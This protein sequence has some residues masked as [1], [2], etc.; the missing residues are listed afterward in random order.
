MASTAPN[1]QF[2]SC[3]RCKEFITTGHAYELGCDRWHTHCFACYKCEKP[4]SCESDFLVLGTGA[5]ICFDCSDSCKNCGKKIDDLAIILSSSNEAYCSDCFKC[6]KCGEN[7][8]DLRY[9]KTKRGLFCLSCHEKLLAKR[10]YYEEK[11][12]R[13]KKNLPSLPTPVID[14]GHTDEV[15]ASAVLPEKTFSRPASLVNEI[16]SGSEPSK[17]IETNSSDIVPHFITGYNDSDDNS[18]SSK[19]GSNVSIDVIGPEENSTEHVNDD[20]KEEAEAPSAN[21]SLNVATDPTLSCKEPPSHSRNLLNKTPLRNSSGQYLAKSPSS[22][23]Q[24]IIV[25]DSLEESDQIDPPNNSSRNASELLTSVLHSPVSVNMKNP[26]GSNT[27]IFNTGEISQMDPSLSRKVLNNIVE[28]TNALQRPVVEVVKEDRSVPDLAGVQQEQA[29][30]YSYSNNSGKG[31]KI[32][33]SLSRRSKDLMINLKSRA[34]GKQD[35]NVKLSPASKVTSRRSQDLMRDNDS[36]TGLDTPN[37]N[38]TS[39]DILVNNQKSLNYKRFTD[40]GTL[41]VTSGKEPALEEQKN[42]SFKSP[43]PIDHLLQS[44]ATPSNVSM[45]RTPPL[46]SSLTFDRRNGSSYSNQNYS[47]PSWQKTPK[48]QLENS[49]NFEEQKETLYENSESRNDPSLDKEIVTAEHYLK[50]L[51]INLKEL[52]SQREELMK[53]ITEMKSMKEAL[54]RHFESYNSE[55]N[56]LYLDSNELSNNPPMINEISLGESPPVKHVATA[57]S[58]ARSSVKP[59]FWK[60]FSSAKPQTEQSIQGVSTNNTNSIVKSAPVLLSAPSSGSNSGRLEISPPVLQNPNEFSDVR[61]VPIENDAN[62]GQSK[63]GEEY[64]DGSNLYGSSLVARCNYENNEIPMIL[65][66]CIDFIESDEEN[67]RSEG[68]YR[69]SGSQLVIEEIEKQFS[70][71]KV[72]QNTETPNILTEQDLNA[73]TGVLKRYLRKLPNP[74]FTFQIYEPLMRLVKSRKMMEN[75]PFVG[76]KLSLEAKNS[77]TYMSSKGALKNIL[78][79]LPREHYR[80]LRVLSEH[81]EKVTRYSHWNRMTLYNLALVFAPGLIRDF[82]GEKDIIDMKERNYIVAFIFGNYKDILT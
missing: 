63:D 16:P 26:K 5:L 69:K 40:N 41:R 61:L 28:E 1:E 52:E 7:I 50:Q 9:A 11:K 6:C 58:V 73:V 49:D 21:M 20:V 82:S 30:K 79:D 72:Q 31:R 77:D 67:M 64:L 37:S 23:R 12:R 43:S 53:E 45:Y 59:K 54:R 68:I 18:G 76:G 75:L 33:R 15:S 36:H 29:E 17:D 81:I 51:K 55:K 71:W 46:D 38:S 14:N 78:E 8:A 39:L 27:D 32:S 65:S 13:L 19:F 4:L 24:G 44:P 62:M 22:Y 34:T 74:I 56:K 70:A 48:T 66:V 10:K 2:P 47:I 42:H 35:S 80:V 3:V 25:N 60:F 57:S